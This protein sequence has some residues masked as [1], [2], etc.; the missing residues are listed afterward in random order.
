MSSWTRLPLPSIIKPESVEVLME[1]SVRNINADGIKVE[2]SR[3]G[4]VEQAL[5][6][7]VVSVLPDCTVGTDLVSHGGMF[8]LPSVVNQKA[9]KSALQT[10]LIGHAK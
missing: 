6:E 2:V 4:A 8:P 1:A 3:T 9:R 10:V 7:V 5:R